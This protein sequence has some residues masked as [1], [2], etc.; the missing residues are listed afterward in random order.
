LAAEESCL[1]RTYEENLEIPEKVTARQELAGCWWETRA[2]WDEVLESATESDYQY[3]RNVIET[4][5]IVVLRHSSLD[6][7]AQAP[8]PSLHMQHTA[9]SRDIDTSLPTQSH[10]QKETCNRHELKSRLPGANA[11]S[12]RRPLRTQRFDAYPS[13]L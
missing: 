13:H 5:L 11:Q 2:N 9:Q 7:Q 6:T 12:G 8:K 1:G 3:V 4:A 10:K